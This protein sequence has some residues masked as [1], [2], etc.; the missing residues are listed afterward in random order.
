M[1]AQKTILNKADISLWAKKE[2]KDGQ[3]YWLPLMIHLEDTMNVSRWLWM[4]WLSDG[5]REFCTDSLNPSDPDTACNLAVFLGALHD[6]GKATPAF[7]TQ[8]GFSNSI[9]LNQMLLEKLER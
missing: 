1:G 4:N 2:E 3:F 8:K 6:I 9:D 5:Q 7:Q